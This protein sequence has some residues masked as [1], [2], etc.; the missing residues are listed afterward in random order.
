MIAS[1]KPTHTELTGSVQLTLKLMYDFCCTVMSIAAIAT[2]CLLFLNLLI[3]L[4][5]TGRTSDVH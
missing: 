4:V 2:D 3:L 1:S 5:F